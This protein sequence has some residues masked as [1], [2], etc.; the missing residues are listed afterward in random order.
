MPQIPT[1]PAAAGAG[2]LCLTPSTGHTPKSHLASARILFRTGKLRC[3]AANYA[4]QMDALETA[5]RYIRVLV[6]CVILP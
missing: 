2:A 3:L 4:G 6:G 1:I 5:T